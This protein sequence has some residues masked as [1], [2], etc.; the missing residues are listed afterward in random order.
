MRKFFC[1]LFII[2]FVVL[3]NSLFSNITT[4]AKNNDE[5]K[6]V[7]ALRKKPSGNWCGKDDFTPN[8]TR[9]MNYFKPKKEFKFNLNSV[10]KAQAFDKY[11]FERESRLCFVPFT[12]A[13]YVNHSKTTVTH[14]FE[15]SAEKST[16]Y[17]T[18]IDAGFQEA[19]RAAMGYSSTNTVKRSCK[20]EV[21]LRPN[22]SVTLE[23][24]PSIMAIDGTWSYMSGSKKVTTY[25]PTYITWITK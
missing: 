5:R 19:F 23:A 21:K 2:L 10:A 15:E 25:Y 6:Q 9:K 14:T 24:A 18:S 20:F 12:V 4:E 8:S 7:T 17:N 1:V 16:T 11:K 13:K 22:Q 3:S